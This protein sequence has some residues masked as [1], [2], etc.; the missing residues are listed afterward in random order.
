MFLLV[1]VEFWI[2]V[3][4]GGLWLLVTGLFV[5][6]CVQLFWVWFW[7][8]FVGCLDVVSFWYMV[9]FIVVIDLVG[10]GVC[11][12]VPFFGCVLIDVV[13]EVLVCCFLGGICGGW[14][15]VCRGVFWFC[16][17]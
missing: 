2:V 1:V 4:V 12:M 10:L 6:G 14:F 7:I 13:L 16:L 17:F 15:V 5:L 9:N 11:L 8:L 3:F